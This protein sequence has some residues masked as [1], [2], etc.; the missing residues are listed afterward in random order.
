MCRDNL[1]PRLIR[2]C[3]LITPVVT[4]IGTK[5]VISTNMPAF[6]IASQREARCGVARITLKVCG[7]FLEYCV[8][9]TVQYH[10][11]VAVAIV[12]VFEK[13]NLTIATARRLYPY[14]RNSIAHT[15]IVRMQIRNITSHSVLRTGVAIST[16]IVLVYRILTRG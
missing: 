13:V 9:S 7:Y 1:A 15:D 4:T 2:V 3:A 10:G 8:S 16:D 14:R 11:P 12:L 5:V 6:C